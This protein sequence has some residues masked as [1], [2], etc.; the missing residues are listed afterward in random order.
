MKRRMREGSWEMVVEVRVV[1][2]VVD[3]LDEGA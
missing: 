2:V 3:G 1:R